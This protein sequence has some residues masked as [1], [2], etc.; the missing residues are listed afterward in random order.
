MAASQPHIIVPFTS[1]SQ[2]WQVLWSCWKS[3]SK[4]KVIMYEQS[5]SSKWELVLM[6]TAPVLQLPYSRASIAIYSLILSKLPVHWCCHLF[7]VFT[8]VLAS[9]YIQLTVH[10]LL[11][12]YFSWKLAKFKYRPHSSCTCLARPQSYKSLLAIF[13]VPLPTGDYITLVCCLH[14]KFVIPNL[15]YAHVAAKGPWL[16]FPNKVPFGVFEM[17][18]SCFLSPQTSHTVSQLILIWWLR[19]MLNWKKSKPCYR[20]VCILLNV[21]TF[22][23][24]CP[25]SFCI[26]FF[27]NKSIF[28]YQ[29]LIL[30]L[31]L[32]SHHSHLS[33]DFA[34]IFCS[35]LY[36]QCLSLHQIIPGSIQTNSVISKIII[37][38]TFP[39]WFPPLYFSVLVT[40]NSLK[41][42]PQH[43][44]RLWL[45]YQAS[46]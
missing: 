2:A 17:T 38:Q 21:H 36:H 22:Q 34:L 44:I 10:N 41:I 5:N 30:P 25:Y 14:F 23:S 20:N 29:S 37:T 12:K 19:L 39:C 4:C 24:L 3:C 40:E 43:S 1:K 31:I 8:T 35:T 46:A 28:S 16:P 42:L 15:K 45:L 27:L 18:V 26:L 13:S 9:L 6:V 32:W 11:S 33:K 7:T